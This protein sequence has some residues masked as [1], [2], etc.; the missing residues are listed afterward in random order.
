M[1][2]SIGQNYRISIFIRFIDYQIM[3]LSTRFSDN[4]MEL[5]ILSSALD[6]RGNYK[7]FNID[8]ICSLAAKFYPQDFDKQEL[9]LLRRQLQHYKIVVLSNQDFQVMSTIS[10]LLQRL[11]ETRK[12]E[13]FHLVDR[14][15]RLVLTLPVST[16]TTER[17]FSAMKILKSELR[18]KMHDE[19]LADCMA[20]YIEMEFSRNIDLESVVVE[21][22]AMQDRRSKFH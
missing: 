4:A 14:L 6:P 16:E 11:V 8:N 12:S 1:V 10:E 15:I 13:I 20:L 2:F 5:L 17:A 18:S 7:S 21:F 9:D 22:A 19:P 3:E